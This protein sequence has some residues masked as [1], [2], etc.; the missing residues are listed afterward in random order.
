METKRHLNTRDYE[1][2][3]I[4]NRSGFHVTNSLNSHFRYLAE[5]S[6]HPILLNEVKNLS[7]YKWDD[8]RVSEAI[9]MPKFSHTLNFQDGSV[10]LNYYFLNA[11]LVRIY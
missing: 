1:H 3:G 8:L 9:Y 7:G 11:C 10:P 2:K 4:S 6:I 5:L